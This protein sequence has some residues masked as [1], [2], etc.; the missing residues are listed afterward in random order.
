VSRPAKS[1]EITGTECIDSPY[2]TARQMKDQ[3]ILRG[4]HEM[5]VLSL[6]V[7]MSTQKQTPESGVRAVSRMQGIAWLHHLQMS[8]IAIGIEP[9]ISASPLPPHLQH[10]VTLRLAV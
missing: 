9:H 3:T 2:D 6:I 4:T 7:N 10:Q 8:R 5:I 1:T